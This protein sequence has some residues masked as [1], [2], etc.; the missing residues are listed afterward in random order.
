M[1]SPGMAPS[2]PL[3]LPHRRQGPVR[4]FLLL[5]LT[6][7]LVQFVVTAIVW[8]W[9]YDV[10]R[11]IQPWMKAH[12]PKFFVFPLILP[13]AVPTFC[14]PQLLRPLANGALWAIT[15]SLGSWLAFM[16]GIGRPGRIILPLAICG[17]FLL[18]PYAG[19]F[20]PLEKGDDSLIGIGGLLVTTLGFVVAMW[21]ILETKR[22]AADAKDSA[23]AAERAAKTTMLENRAHFLK[24][25]VSFVQRVFSLAAKHIEEKKWIAAGD[26]LGIAAD[27][28]A[29]VQAV[30]S[31]QSD[32]SPL[33]NLGR[34][35]RQVS[36]LGPRLENR[37]VTQES[38][39]LD[40]WI[41]LVTT[42][43]DVTNQMTTA[44]PVGGQE[45]Q[46]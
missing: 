24:F 9:P 28:I 35:L 2:S 46:T 1:I 14:W 22:L 37:T 23:I 10:P 40:H 18:V 20:L 8:N 27:C 34:Q 38:F 31:D 16:A 30:S 43:W 12:V 11:F 17:L 26:F 5:F 15:I 44:L 32:S 25:E 13:D 3:S 21:Q 4:F 36:V 39:Q 33:A 42:F 41:P 45:L 7:W 19:G 6:V 29:Q